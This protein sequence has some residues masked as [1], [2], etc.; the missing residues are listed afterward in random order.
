MIFL[1]PLNQRSNSIEDTCLFGSLI[2]SLMSFSVV[3]GRSVAYPAVVSVLV[4]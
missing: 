3:Q 1:P 4:G 2:S